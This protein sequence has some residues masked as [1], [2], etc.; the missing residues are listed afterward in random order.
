MRGLAGTNSAYRRHECG[1]TAHVSVVGRYRPM[2]RV[3]LF[4]SGLQLEQFIRPWYWAAMLAV[5]LVV[6]RSERPSFDGNYA[7]AG[8]VALVVSIKLRGHWWRK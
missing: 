4:A 3:D 7:D 1:A 5:P 6:L 8:G 2:A